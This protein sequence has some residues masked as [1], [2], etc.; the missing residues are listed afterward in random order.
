MC[1]YT[2]HRVMASRSTWAFSSCRA[3][4]RKDDEFNLSF[5]FYS[6]LVIEHQ[7]LASSQI[8]IDGNLMFFSFV[9]FAENPERMQNVQQRK[10]EREREQLTRTKKNAKIGRQIKSA[11][12][13]YIAWWSPVRSVG[14]LNHARGRCV[15]V[16]QQA[17]LVPQVARA[18]N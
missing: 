16:C 3:R 12:H 8:T 14:S 6:Y 9:V 1:V 13:V 2:C 5:F 11:P 18:L 7:P 15:C 4:A 10:R 17:G